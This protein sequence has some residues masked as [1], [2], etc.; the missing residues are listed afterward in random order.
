LKKIILSFSGILLACSVS[1]SQQI[2]ERTKD[3]IQ[4]QRCAT[5]ERVQMLFKKFPERKLLAEK[6][7]KETPSSN[8]LRQAQRLTS[9]IY[10]PVVFHVVLSNPYLI[11][12][13]TIQAQMSALNTDF[14]G[15]NADSTNIPAA[16]QAVRG[17]SMIQFVLAKR[18]PS[19]AL[20]NGVERIS[21]SA[22][23]NPNNVT[24][25]IKRAS[26]GGADAWDPNTYI[27]IWVGEISGNLGVLGY[28]Q[29]PGSGL[30]IDDGIF[31]NKVG[32][33][34][35]S[36][37]VSYYN[38]GRT[39]VHEM[40]HYFGLN[41]TWGDDEDDSNK[42]SGDD[43]RAM[44]DDGSSFVLPATLYNPHGQGN[45]SSDIGDTPNQSIA[46]TNCSSGT[47]TDACSPSAPGIMYQ[48]YMDYTMDDC[49]SMFTKKQVERMEYVL[50]NFRAGL[51]TSLG[52]TPPTGA[53]TR[54]AAPIAAI[55]PGG[56]ETSGCTSIYHPSTLTCGGDITPMVLIENKGLNKITSITVGYTLN[57]GSPVTVN[58]TPGL[59]FGITQMV[60]FPA[61]SVNPGS[62]TFKF[63]T[64]NVNGSGNDQVVAN[65]TL[66]TTLNV[67]NPSPV[68]LSE[69]FENTLFP[70]AGWSLLNEDN[71]VTWQNTTPGNNSAHS[72][73]INNY[74][75]NSSGQIDEIRTPKLTFSGT[76]PITISFDLAHKNYPDASFNDRLQVLVSND[77]G[78]TFT[79]YFDKSG[80]NLATAGSSSD[81][82]LNPAPADW[83]TQKITLDGSVLNNGNIIVAFRNTSDWGNNIYIDNINIKQA[84]ARDLSVTAINPPAT[85]DCEE[86]TTPV[87]TVQNNGLSTVTGFKVSYQ[88]D[89][90]ASSVTTVSNISLAP[91]AQTTVSL[92][93]FTP[94]GGQHIIK[95]YTS[96]PVSASGSGD[97][98]PAN[99]TLS[100][101]FNALGLV[102]SPATEGFENAAFPPAEWALEN[103][104]GGITWKRT[105]DAAKTGNASMLIPNYNYTS[106]GTIDKFISSVI[107]DAASYDTMYVSFDYSYATRLAT[108]TADTL[109]LQI[110]TDCGQ[111]FT[112]IWKQ[113]G[114]NLQTASAVSGAFIPGAANDWASVNINLWQYVGTKNFQVYFVAKGNKQ[115]NLYI[116]NINIYGIT[117]PPLL[118]K[119]G[120][121]IY[122]NPFSGQFFI[123]NYEVP[124]T[125]QGAYVYNALGQLIWSKQYNGNAYTQ[126]PVDLGNA[127]RGI[128]FVKLQY[129]DRSV[130]QKI[131]KE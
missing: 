72:M 91:G 68:P 58:L 45:T 92:N 23:G 88:V 117:V 73:Y 116:D 105:T 71:N 63:F 84:K 54:D 15:L 39:V 110:T 32:F 75:D 125:L 36:C 81:S 99:D 103:P 29:V 106:T 70:P 9:V 6:L 34:I 56:I 80:A 89:N 95:V 51:L 41:H 104:D 79:S 108:G 50:S 37:N 4:Y 111:T 123:R 82:Y 113:Y 12:D 55:N 20:T 26:L 130:V 1:F 49:Y 128:Y 44:T 109:E 100:K 78:L 127:P 33:G 5:I 52:G 47:V 18:T 43:F 107:S 62:Y 112:T 115:N 120:Y 31:C 21:S 11:T 8:R 121:L 40:G 22:K 30:L 86:P 90:G 74:D 114:S 67:P 87:A 35:S 16:F 83:K 48:N 124:V 46:S 28:T 27:N 7:A 59:D 53:A 69:G 98:S 102:T 2:S 60:S 131:I 25:S 24:D 64:K 61:I 126:M 119:Q 57:G 122:P 77:C 38:K 76:D 96:D 17:H 10:V 94:S 101:S 19:G 42:C 85:T 66:A 129:T 14:A 97:E 3:N 13:E 65:D 118:K 93:S